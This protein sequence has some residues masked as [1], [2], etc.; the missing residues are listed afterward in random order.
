MPAFFLV[1][2]LDDESDSQACLRYCNN[3]GKYCDDKVTT[4]SKTRRP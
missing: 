2:H 1:I 3:N 4:H